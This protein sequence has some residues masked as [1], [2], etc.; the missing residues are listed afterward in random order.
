MPEGVDLGGQPEQ[1]LGRT[2]YGR[3]QL[4]PAPFNNVLVGSYVFLAGLPGPRRCWPHC[5][6]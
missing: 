2:Y 5:W 1:G 3:K 4:K 6:T